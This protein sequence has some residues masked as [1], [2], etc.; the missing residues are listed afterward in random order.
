MKRLIPWRFPARWP[1]FRPDDRMLL[2]I[3]GI[4]VG[5]CSGIA[6]LAL[7]KSLIVML[8]FLHHYRH[9]WWAFLLPAAGAALSSL[10]LN[11]IV[12]EGAGHGVPEVI[13]AV[14]RYGGL[15]RLRSSFSRL[16]SSCLTIGS[17]GSAGPEAP[18]VMSGAAIGS[19]IAT[20][21]SLN[22]R[23]RVTLVGCGA[24]GAIA[25]IFNA[26]IAGF[27]FVL[28]IVLGEWSTV[29]IVPIA[30]ASVA[31]AETS[32]LLAGNQIAFSH[33]L[34]HIGSQDIMACAGLAVLTALVSILLTRTMRGMHHQAGKLKLPLWLKAAIG[35]CAVGLL[36]FLIPDVLGEGYHSIR[37]MIEGVYS[38]G[39]L[40]VSLACLAKILATSLTLGWGGSGGI[41][42]PSLVIGSFTGLAYARGL[43]WLF[44]D[45]SWVNEGC[46][47]LL[48]M[49]G[50]IG[51]I[52]QAPLTGL[53]LI[54][55]ITGGYEVI[56]P[57]IIVSSLST[58]ICYYFEPAS[59][60][61]KDLVDRGQ[62]LR[63]G[64]DA[65]V[66][67]DLSISELLET[68]CIS[69]YPE[70]PLKEFLG[71]VTRSRRNYFPVED[72]ETGKFIG[73]VRFDD[74]RPYLFN[75]MMH[76][77]VYVEQIMSTDVDIVHYDDDLSEILKIMD[78]K[79]LYSLPVISNGRFAGMISKATLLDKYRKELMVQTQT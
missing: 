66:L 13:Y 76:D 17:G 47:A 53:F 63:P 57:L 70:M 3:I 23:Q 71:I 37:D 78:T 43:S 55:E 38:H 35:G 6:A 49:A 12:N 65:R 60:Y 18:V 45:I 16:V 67:T 14:S 10:F 39:F 64:T 62:L 7:N 61:M 44:P 58:T 24:A 41:F 56:L 42:A 34:F 40:I 11:K 75:R 15:L 52:L 5:T 33:H 22:D 48:G 8:D 51:G 59:F 20:A 77:T 26:P 31:G 30:V 72:R 28:E 21:M 27:V 69:V 4:F 68:D 32:R 19:N 29:N 46:F 74:I 50:L 36:G 25:S 9:F 1:V 73:I 79:K 2:I 54:V